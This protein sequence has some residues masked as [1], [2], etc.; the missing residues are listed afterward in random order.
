MNDLISRSAYR[1]KLVKALEFLEMELLDAIVNE[2]RKMIAAIQ[3]QRSAYEVAITI[4]DNEQITYDVNKVVNWLEKD[5]ELAEKDK[6]RCIRESLL[7]Q[8]NVAK[9]YATAISNTIDVVKTGGAE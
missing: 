7:Q 8:Y 2:D 9:G 5:L 6:E 1:N 4:L 3:N